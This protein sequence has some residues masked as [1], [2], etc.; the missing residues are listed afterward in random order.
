MVFYNST[1]ERTSSKLNPHR[2]AARL[3]RSAARSA[4][5]SPFPAWHS[6]LLLCGS[7]WGADHHPLGQRG[8]RG[9]WKGWGEMWLLGIS[10]RRLKRWCRDILVHVRKSSLRPT[11]P[12]TKT[13]ALW[14]LAA[15]S[16]LMITIFFQQK[17]ANKNKQTRI[18]HTKKTDLTWLLP[19]LRYNP[20]NNCTLCKRTKSI[21]RQGGNI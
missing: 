5:P 13:G 14:A 2:P 20:L 17:P 21:H 9:L 11:K 15:S 10:G 3:L 16:P 12:S 7:L 6:R 18:Q 8:W 19:F 4:P 1:A